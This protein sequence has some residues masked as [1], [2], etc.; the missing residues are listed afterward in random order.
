MMFDLNN[1]KETNGN[2][3]RRR[4]RADPLRVDDLRKANRGQDRLPHRR[5]S[6]PRCRGVYGEK[7]DSFAERLLKTASRPGARHAASPSGSRSG[8]LG[9]GPEEWKDAR[10]IIRLADED[11]LLE[12]RGKG[13]W[14]TQPGDKVRI[15]MRLLS[16]AVVPPL[17][18]VPRS[19]SARVAE[20][21]GGFPRRAPGHPPRRGASARPSGRSRRPC[22]GAAPRELAERQVDG[23]AATLGRAR[24]DVALGDHLPPRDAG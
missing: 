1:L 16:E 6:S 22:R 14:T 7:A 3:G 15:G 5:G 24:G 21:A 13:T 12:R 8:S 2:C 17:A 18:L 20:A 23:G 11:A 4:Q 10:E 19:R 9:A